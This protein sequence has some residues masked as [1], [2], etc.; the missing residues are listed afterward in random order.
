MA[1]I[2]L[3]SDPFGA[4]VESAQQDVELGQNE[5]I[6]KSPIRRPY[7]GIQ[8]KK[9][10]Y[11]TISIR[12]PDGKEIPLVSSSDTKLEH[13]GFVREYSDYI[14]QNVQDQ[15]MEKQQIIETFGDSYI[16]FYG[17]RPRIMQFS[18]L[19]INSEDFN[20][21]SQFWHNY[22]TYMRG[23]KLV[24]MNARAY[25]TWDTVVVEGYILTASATE[26]A[27]DQH[28]IPFNISL[29]VTNYHDWSNIGQTRFPGHGVSESTF[30]VLNDALALQRQDFAST[31]A[32]VRFKSYRAGL[33]GKGALGVLRSG[34]R[35]INEFTSGVSDFMGTVDRVIGGRTVRLP[36]GISGYLASVGRATIGAGGT[37]QANTTQFD[38]A[39]G[40][41]ESV[42]GSVRLRVPAVAKFAPA[43][44]SIDGSYRGHFSDNL[45]EYPLYKS[46]KS[47]MN[48]LKPGGQ[49]KRLEMLREKRKRALTA[50]DAAV[51]N[52]KIIQE[53]GGP[54]DDITEAVSFAR[55]NF[56]MV[57][58]AAAFARDPLTTVQQFVGIGQVF[59]FKDGTYSVREK[60]L[61]GRLSQ[62][63]GVNAA[64][65]F[66][67]VV[68]GHP[69]DTQV[70][71]SYQD[72]T[73]QG[74]DGDIAFE[75]VYGNRDYSALVAN[76]PSLQDS[77][78][79]LSGSNDK[80]PGGTDLQEQNV[81]GVYDESS[82]SSTSSGQQE[83]AGLLASSIVDRDEDAS[84]IRAV[85]DED[86]RIDPIR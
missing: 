82:Y 26:D 66:A 35:A 64:K 11:S 13:D 85:D 48:L 40:K 42:T 44:Q 68:A 8:V 25:I 37:S 19:L 71:A 3:T 9:D 30:S 29:V 73:Y 53:A 22:E 23:T 36:Q 10:T 60:A 59:D 78:D 55:S 56:G 84:G 74:E 46:E 61:L 83:I 62:F 20:W 34:I 49:T 81:I 33:K 45:D 4:T 16:Y 80:A 31:T 43:W 1:Y 32:D 65:T 27:N 67:S 18:G 2:F 52:H 17:E 5:G 12:T 57:A 47:L 24:Q 63:V 39:T 14:L 79:E 7:R 86:S 77:L 6:N 38:A 76:D 75:P 54:L 58:S 69:V 50:Y 41:F 70:G 28:N 51:L 15:R 21:R 72:G